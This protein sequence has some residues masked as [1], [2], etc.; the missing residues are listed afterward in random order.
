MGTIS[1]ALSGYYQLANLLSSGSGSSTTGSDATSTLAELEQ[2]LGI[3]SSNGSSSNGADSYLLDLSPQA[4]A[5][6]NGSSAGG[7][8][9]SSSGSSGFTLTQT[10]ET[11]IQNI[12]EQY[13]DAPMTQATF[14]EIQNAL[15]SAGLSAQTLGAEDQVNSFDGTKILVQDLDGNYTGLQTAGTTL[16]GEQTKESNYMQDI[17]KAWKALEAS[18]GGGSSSSSGSSISSAS[19]ASL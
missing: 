1:S 2:E 13:K 15:S 14:Q 6:L 16:Q 19:G 8:S 5:L 18:S 10:Q 3:S 7:L 11:A 4:Q 12:L 9:G 17:A